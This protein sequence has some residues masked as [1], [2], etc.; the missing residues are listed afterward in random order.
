MRRLM[1]PHRRPLTNT[2]RAWIRASRYR[3]RGCASGSSRSLLGSA[4]S[5]VNVV[6]ANG[7][8]FA[9]DPGLMRWAT[10][11]RRSSAMSAEDIER[12]LHVIAEIVGRWLRL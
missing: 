2:S 7:F 6:S 8:W 5:G 12:H 3:W 4:A 10:S 9:D 11:D 1:S